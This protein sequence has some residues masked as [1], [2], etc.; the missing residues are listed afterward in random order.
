MRPSPQWGVGLRP[1]RGG[2]SPNGDS[3]SGAGLRGSDLFTAKSQHVGLGL[4]GDASQSAGERRRTLGDQ[5]G[6]VLRCVHWL[7][8]PSSGRG[9]APAISIAVCRL[10]LSQV[11]APADDGRPGSGRQ[12]TAREWPSLIQRDTRSS[13]AREKPIHHTETQRAHCFLTHPPPSPPDSP[14]GA[15]LRGSDLF[16][17]KSQHVG[18]GLLGDAS[19]SAGERLRGP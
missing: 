1:P 8:T 12:E 10:A 3:P 2:S 13:E 5:D 4:L 19:Q 16:T 14:S 9:L 6:S 15:G 17:A 18:L 11:R 7:E